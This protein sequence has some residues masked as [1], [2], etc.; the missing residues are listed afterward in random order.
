MPS[1]DSHH[2]TTT[3]LRPFFRDHPGEPVP[4]ENFWTLWCKGRLTEADMPC[5]DVS[6]KQWC[7]CV[8]AGVVRGFRD[9]CAGDGV[10]HC[11]TLWVTAIVCF[12]INYYCC[13]HSAVCALHRMEKVL[14]DWSLRLCHLGSVV[15]WNICC[16]SRLWHASWTCLF[17]YHSPLSD[18]GTWCYA[19]FYSILL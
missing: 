18:A 3:V 12:G 8:H 10:S 11:T 13:L 16:W 2:H 19:V 6:D 14:A 5:F 9:A 15:L 4:E 7:L 17:S 1:F